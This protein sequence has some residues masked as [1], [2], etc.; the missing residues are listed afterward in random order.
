MSLSCNAPCGRG[1]LSGLLGHRMEEVQQVTLKI[2]ASAPPLSSAKVAH[3]LAPGSA[4]QTL[5]SSMAA[6]LGTADSWLRLGFVP[7][8][9]CMALWGA[10]E[11]PNL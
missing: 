4:F 5:L 11:T 10:G 6:A 3:A 2:S 9:L 1:L 7:W 8:V